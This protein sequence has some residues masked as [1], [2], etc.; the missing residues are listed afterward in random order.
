MSSGSYSPFISSMSL[1]NNRLEIIVAISDKSVNTDNLIK[2][3]ND[4]INSNYSFVLLAIDAS[5]NVFKFRSENNRENNITCD[6][7]LLLETPYSISDK[8]E[9]KYRLTCND[10]SIIMDLYYTVIGKSKI[11]PLLTRSNR[12]KIIKIMVELNFN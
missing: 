2:T 5:G 11:V 6:N 7:S 12:I 10:G 1:K 8:I 3:S 9:S 4:I